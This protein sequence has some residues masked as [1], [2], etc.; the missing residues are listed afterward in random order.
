MDKFIEEFKEF[1]NDFKQDMKHI[2]NDMEE[3]ID[4][5]LC[6]GSSNNVVPPWNYNRNTE[7]VVQEEYVY[8]ISDFQDFDTPLDKMA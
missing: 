7:E 5:E 4:R 8:D 6:M 3:L 1:W 2:W